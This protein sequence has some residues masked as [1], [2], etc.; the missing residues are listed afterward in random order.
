MAKSLAIVLLLHKGRKVKRIAIFA[1]GTW[2]SP[3]QGIATNVLQIARAISPVDTEGVPQVVFYDW[4]VGTEQDKYSGGITG[5]GIDKNIMDCYRFLVHN[6][7]PND[8]LYFFGFSRGA[9]TVRSLCGLI[10]NSGLLRSEHADKIP[11][12]YKLY[13]ERSKSS[14]PNQ[15]K[16]VKF[17]EQ[18]A[19]SDK[20]NIKFVGAWD[21]VG[22]LGIPMPF[23]GGLG[24]EKYL[25]H[26]LEPSQ[27]IQHARHAV[28]IDE[29]R[30]DFSATLWENKQD[31][32]LQQ[33]WFAGVHSDV[34]GGYKEDGLSQCASQ[35][36]IEQSQHFGV[37]FENHLLEKIHPNYADKQH[38][39]RKSFY[40]LRR[41]FTRE[42]TGPLHISVKRRWDENV[43]GYQKKSKALLK[44]LDSVN[45]DWSKIV[46]LE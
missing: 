22:A 15:S 25:F 11:Q 41:E 30:E 13:R 19:V 35:W 40:K 21:T 29:N 10:R 17:R 31:I 12:A 18:F 5:S 26:D 45:G 44:L 33:V 16:S 6:Y 34:G 28:S 14:S 20:T 4:G 39:E 46:V 36:M 2:N 43:Q 9:Y 37:E 24:K 7:K 1:D 38:N 32:D 27:I 23:L 42:V 8:Q 3:E